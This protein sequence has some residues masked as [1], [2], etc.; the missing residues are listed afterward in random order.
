MAGS[1][2]YFCARTYTSHALYKNVCLSVPVQYCSVVF[3]SCNVCIL[4]SSPAAFTES[5]HLYN[6][7]TSDARPRSLRLTWMLCLGLRPLVRSHSTDSATHRGSPPARWPVHRA[8]P[9][10]LESQ[11]FASV[12]D[13]VYLFIYLFFCM[14]TS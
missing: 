13:A 14:F 10:V 9:P 2:L 4:L 3:F 6:G 12:H 8:A 5:I 1:C 11:P 7:V